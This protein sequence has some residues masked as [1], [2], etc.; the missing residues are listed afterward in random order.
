MP[1][2]LFLAEPMPI[3]PT[4]PLPITRRSSRWARP[5]SSRKRRP[6][7]ALSRCV[8]VTP[9]TISEDGHFIGQDGFVVP[10]SFEE[11]F[12]RHPRYVRGRVRLCWP[13][14]TDLEREDHESE[15]LI[16]LMSLPDKSKFRALS[17]N[18]FPDG[19]KDRIQTFNPDLAYGASEPRFFNYIKIILTNRLITLWQKAASNPVRASNTSSLYSP[20][21]D[22]TL[23]DE[24]YIC[25]LASER[26]AFGMSYDQAIQNG[27]LVDEFLRFVKNHNPELLEVIRAIQTTDTYVGAQHALGLTERLFIRARSRLVV[28]YTCFDKG[29]DPPR[30]RK[31]YNVSPSGVCAL[32]LE[33]CP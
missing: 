27:I 19:C 6:L 3:L 5:Q 4:V 10:R 31:V 28:L 16:F 8:G 1:P 26:G 29:T 33:S 23:L 22:G 2:V 12:E 17:Y 25:A 18:G 30:Q 24:D 21:P 9:Y 15:L 11:F 14:G 13:N 20:E 7:H 32:T